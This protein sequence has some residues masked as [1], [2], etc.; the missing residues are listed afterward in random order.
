VDV[1]QLWSSNSRGRRTAVVVEQ[2]WS[3]NSRGRRT[4]VVVEQPW[5]SNSR[6]RRTAAVFT[7]VHVILPSVDPNPAAA[8]VLPYTS[9]LALLLAY[10][11]VDSATTATLPSLNTFALTLSKTS[12]VPSI[13]GT[14]S[15][16][17][18]GL[19]KNVA[20]TG[21]MTTRPILSNTPVSTALPAAPP[22]C[23]IGGTPPYTSLHLLCAGV[24]LVHTTKSN[25]PTSP[26]FV[27]TVNFPGTVRDTPVTTSPNLVVTPVP[28]ASSAEQTPPMPSGPGR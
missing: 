10:S 13:S 28:C 6:G 25:S 21:T 7:T 4:A 11:G 8:L 15:L 18:P 16:S 12:P 20:I 17:F 14:T 22:Y 2:P 27:V 24:A 1:E 19:T 23:T 9:L 3:S 26:L 5:S